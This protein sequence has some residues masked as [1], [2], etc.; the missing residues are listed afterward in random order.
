M[1]LVPILPFADFLEESVA[2]FLLLFAFLFFINAEFIP[3]WPLQSPE[4]LMMLLK[5]GI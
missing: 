4:Q 5:H 2:G 1:F 3:L